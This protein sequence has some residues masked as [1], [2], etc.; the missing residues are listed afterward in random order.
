MSG[1]LP[2][3]VI[4]Y[5]GVLAV[6]ARP[7]GMFKYF[8]YKTMFSFK[9]VLFATTIA[10]NLTLYHYYSQIR[11]RFVPLQIHNELRS[12]VNKIPMPHF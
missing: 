9:S 4:L 10:S 3:C 8:L 5:V 11:K 12:I 2:Q 7:K 6:Q 1:L